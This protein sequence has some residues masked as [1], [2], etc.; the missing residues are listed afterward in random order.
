MKKIC[1]IVPY[2]GK[3]PNNFQIWLKSCEY[4]PT[5]NWL[6]FTNDNTEYDYPENVKVVYCSFNDIKQRIQK[7]YDFKIMIDTYWR[8]SFFKPAYGEIFSDYLKEYDYWGHCDIDLL[9]GNI[10]KFITD[11]ILEKYDKIGFQGHSTIYKNSIEVNSRYKTI[12]PDEITYIDEFSGKTKSCFDE[13]G[14][15]K[16]YN[17]L[18]I[19]YYKETNFAHLSKY[20][21]SFFLKYLPESD[22]Y[23]NNRQVFLLNENGLYRYYIDKNNEINSDEFMYI[24]FFCRPMKFKV[25]DVDRFNYIIYPDIVSDFSMSKPDKKFIMNKGKC[26]KVKYYVTSIWYNRKKLTFKRIYGNIIRMIKYKKEKK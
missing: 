11:E 9:W 13:N 7:N 14:M 15:E 10:R 5:V 26:S 21:Y 3:L 18:N 12:V 24:H 19:P 8:L 16:I 23:K 1:Y 20:D 25:K 22:E 6:I 17:F 2:F 4:N